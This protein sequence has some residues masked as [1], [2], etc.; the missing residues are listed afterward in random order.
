MTKEELSRWYELLQGEKV[1]KQLGMNAPSDEHNEL[2]RLN[3]DVME[4]CHDIH[5]TNM[6]RKD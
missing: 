1:C 3:G 4:V 2:I 5:N 6:L